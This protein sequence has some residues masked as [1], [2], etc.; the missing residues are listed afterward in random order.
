MLVLYVCW[1]WCR[2]LIHLSTVNIAKITN[3]AT[4]QISLRWSIPCLSYCIHLIYNNQKILE[5]CNLI[6]QRNLF[7]FYHEW[8]NTKGIK[9]TSVMYSI[10]H[11]I[12]KI[13][14]FNKNLPLFLYHELNNFIGINTTSKT[15][16]INHIILKICKFNENFTFNNV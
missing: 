12:L 13:H 6:N 9:T 8:N 2:I 3:C 15:C 4:S 5:R 1:C 14:E 16:N 7:F 11:I 10:N